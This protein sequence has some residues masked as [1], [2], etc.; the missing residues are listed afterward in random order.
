MLTA[1]L[2]GMKREGPSNHV[3]L[4]ATT[5]LLNFLGFNCVKACFDLEVCSMKLLLIFNPS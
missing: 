4:A 5:A 2:D 1:I 3:R